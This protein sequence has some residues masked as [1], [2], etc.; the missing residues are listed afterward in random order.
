MINDINPF[1]SQNTEKDIPNFNENEFTFYFLKP[2]SFQILKDND[3][4]LK[5]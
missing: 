3:L 4:F 2:I 1:Y 5:L